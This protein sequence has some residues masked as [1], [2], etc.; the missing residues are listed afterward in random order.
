MSFIKLHSPQNGVNYLLTFYYLLILNSLVTPYILMRGPN[1]KMCIDSWIDP[2]TQG[3]NLPVSVLALVLQGSEW[4][5]KCD[6]P[7]D[8]H[9]GDGLK[10]RAKLIRSRSRK[11]HKFTRHS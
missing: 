5:L 3:N 9:P 6:P 11:G 8:L 7:S 1:F 4:G 10:P 2:Y